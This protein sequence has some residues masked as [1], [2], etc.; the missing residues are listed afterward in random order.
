MQAVVLSSGGLDSSLTMHLLKKQGIE[1]Y[2]LHINYG[3]LAEP[4]EWTAC[5]QMCSDLGIRPPE[6]MDLSGLRM[7][8]SGLVN[9]NL[10]IHDD[11]FLPTRNLIFLVVGAGYAYSKGLDAVV[12]GLVA[13]PIFPDQTPAFVARAEDAI[14]EALGHRV[15]VLAPLIRLDKREVILL[16]EAHGLNLGLAYYCHRGG[17]KPCGVCISCRERI[18]A[19]KSVQGAQLGKEAGKRGRGTARRKRGMG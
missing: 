13:N 8:P 15:K 19:E 6:C 18:A 4:K 1:V 12:I 9:P 5:R 17:E 2:P 10:D 7:F 14:A 11:A 16:A 3:Q